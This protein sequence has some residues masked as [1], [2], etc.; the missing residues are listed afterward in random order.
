MRAGNIVTTSGD[1]STSLGGAPCSCGD[2]SVIDLELAPAD[3]AAI[4]FHPDPVWET[5]A[6]LGVLAHPATHP[7]HRDLLDR[8][9]EPD[10]DHDL[11][12]SMM[13]SDRWYPTTLAPVPHRSPVDPIRSLEAVADTDE[14]IA[15]TDLEALRR[16]FP[17]QPRWRTYTVPRLLED[18]ATALVG[19]FGRVLAPLWER[20]EDITASDIAYRSSSLASDGVGVTLGGLHERLTYDAGRLRLQ[21]PGHH[22]HRQ[23]GGEGVR[24]VPSVFRWP[25]LVAELDSAPPVVSY[26]ARGAARLWESAPAAEAT[27]LDPV[28]GR[29][30]VAILANLE[31]PSTT[32]RL[33]R[34]LRLSNGTVSEH[35]TA[36]Q[37]AGLLQ[38]SR[39]GREVLYERTSLGH[40]LILPQR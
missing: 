28:L 20:V 5:V 12:V 9:R 8:V 36:M 3:V 39:R 34:L 1:V 7:L 27:G 31:T 29:S 4:R 23:M 14:D 40:A 10:W 19:Y 38:S 15:G 24:L 21:M 6:S 30:R 37:R 17:D 35:L 2:S 26:A 16:T 32:T 22:E 25:C 13:A 18:T 11:L 33:A